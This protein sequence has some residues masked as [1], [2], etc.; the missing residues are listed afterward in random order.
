MYHIPARFGYV[1][2]PK[3]NV[4]IYIAKRTECYLVWSG[5]MLPENLKYMCNKHD[6]AMFWHLQ[7]SPK[8]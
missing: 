4:L 5:D 6:N 2:I 3:C 8:F 1:D 7:R